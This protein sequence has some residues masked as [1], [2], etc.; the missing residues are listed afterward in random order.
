MLWSFTSSLSLSKTLPQPY[1]SPTTF[2]GHIP[3]NRSHLWLPAIVG[4]LFML[5]MGF[6]LFDFA[7]WFRTFDAHSLWHLATVGIVPLW[8]TFLTK[9]AVCFESAEGPSRT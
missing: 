6:E 4:V 7:P 9:D 3:A 5:A 8:W 2:S 1:L